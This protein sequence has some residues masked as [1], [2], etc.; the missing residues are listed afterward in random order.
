MDDFNLQNVVLDNEESICYISDLDTFE[1]LYINDLGRE[2]FKIKGDEYKGKKCY[3]VLQGNS[4]KCSF[5]NNDRLCKN[6]VVEKEHY[7]KLIGKQFQLL[8]TIIEW[9]GKDVR[10]ELAVDI[11]SRRNEI[12]NL[13]N[14]LLFEETLL[15][16]AQAL[17]LHKD[18][19]V[20]INKLLEI[21]CNFFGA[22]R[23]Y[24]F[25]ISKDGNF[26]NNTYE[27]AIDG[28][29]PEIAN[30]QLVPYSFVA[31]WF[32]KFENQ[33]EF[34]ISSLNEDEDIQEDT[35]NI[36]EPQGIES[37]LAA[38]LVIEIGRASCRERVC[39]YV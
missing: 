18:M 10:M 16:C 14:K 31:S 7:N 25:E 35:Y 9:Q 28:V 19:N 26:V 4:E 29:N 32:E 17:S 1:L 2:L 12:D 21:I 36:L 37:L 38:P 27:W 39:L 6:K 13:K 34:Y 5:C 23:S 3:S 20:A 33:G 24:I 8:D 30:L 11:S 22:D 15:K